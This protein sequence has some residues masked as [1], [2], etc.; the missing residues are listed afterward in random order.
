MQRLALISIRETLGLRA[1]T[2][3]PEAGWLARKLILGLQICDI[4]RRHDWKKLPVAMAPPC[5]LLSPASH[6]CRYRTLLYLLY[7]LENPN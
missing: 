5:P 4:N 2:K 1:P 7:L 6:G 3:L